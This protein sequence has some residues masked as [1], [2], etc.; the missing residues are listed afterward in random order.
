M[1]KWLN[2][3]NVIFNSITNSYDFGVDF[4]HV[5]LNESNESNNTTI[6]DTLKNFYDK[7]QTFFKQRMFMLYSTSTAILPTESTIMEWYCA[8][9]T[10]LDTK[11]D[12]AIF[13]PP[14]S[15]NG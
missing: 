7:C 10:G 13:L 1:E 14:E 9:G 2:K 15:N 4:N 6:T 3:L 12:T 5:F 11:I 8:G